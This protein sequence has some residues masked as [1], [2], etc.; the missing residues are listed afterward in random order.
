MGGAEWISPALVGA[1]LLAGYYGRKRREAKSEGERDAVQINTAH[2]LEDLKEICERRLD[3]HSERMDT[4][5]RDVG[6]TQQRVSRIEGELRSRAS[7]G[8]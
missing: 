2:A 4:I 8:C 7:R 5:Q 6:N 1:G 3:A